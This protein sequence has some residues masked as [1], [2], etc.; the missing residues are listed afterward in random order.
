M[1][2]KRLQG[3]VLACCLVSSSFPVH[4][5]H[6]PASHAPSFSFESQA[7][8]PTI[9]LVLSPLASAGAY[10][11]KLLSPWASVDNFWQ[12]PLKEFRLKW[13]A[14]PRAYYK[15]HLNE[16]WLEKITRVVSLGS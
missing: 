14:H 2:M 16:T 5:L 9:N 4:G 15:A 12:I 3:I 13:V 8:T 1:W 7:L 10:V 11:R 6:M